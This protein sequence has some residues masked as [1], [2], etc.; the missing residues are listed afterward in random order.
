LL[1]QEK[2]GI[3]LKMRSK[4]S[5]YIEE[6]GSKIA[7]IGGSGIGE[8]LFTKG[9]KNKLIKTKYGQVNVKQGKVNEKTIIFLNRHGKQY[10]SPSQINYKANISAL[11]TE[12]VNKIIA[13]A[14]V[15]SINPKLKPGSF[16]LLSDFIDFTKRRDETFSNKSFIDVSCPYDSF[17]KLKLE[18]AAAKQRIKLHRGATYV[19][20]EGPRFETQ[21]EIK[22]FAQLRA[23]VVGMTQVPE[24]ILAKETDIP[25]AVIAIA[26][27]YAAGISRKKVSAEE[28]MLV[29]AQSRK[30]LS[31]LLEQAIKS[32]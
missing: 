30:K 12:G 14:A 29:M 26:T 5:K 8:L 1:K 23:D 27:N 15:G 3:R 2:W 17:L 11:K 7:I 9:F 6:L 13:T 28:V 22:M 20:T 25:Y 19:C 24:V 16:V 32:F 4:A 10:K 31:L 21:A 18:K